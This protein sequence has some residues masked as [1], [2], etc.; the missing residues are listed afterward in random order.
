MIGPMSV[1]FEN[2]AIVP[3]LV[4]LSGLSAGLQTKELPVI[5]SQGTGLGCRPSPQWEA[6]ERQPHIDVSLPFFLPS[7]LSKNK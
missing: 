1:D 3:W 2:V 6:R 7:L 5:P 4:W